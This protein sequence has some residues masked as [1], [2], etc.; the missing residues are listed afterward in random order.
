MIWTFY[1][2]YGLV[3][4]LTDIFRPLQRWLTGLGVTLGLRQVHSADGGH[5]R[6]T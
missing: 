5:E 3:E 4:P 2:S 6:S 1:F